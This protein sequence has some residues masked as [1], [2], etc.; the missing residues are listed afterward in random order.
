MSKSGPR[1]RILGSS[2]PDPWLCMAAATDPSSRRTRACQPAGRQDRQQKRRTGPKNH[3]ASKVSCVQLSKN[4]HGRA[5]LPSKRPWPPISIIKSSIVV[6]PVESSAPIR[7][8]R[9]VLAASSKMAAGYLGVWV[10]GGRLS[11]AAGLALRLEEDEDVVF[12]DC[13]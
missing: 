8:Q 3:E 1:W 10:G 7:L 13:R 2:R 12:A 5:V 6:N 4:T 11:Q 9:L